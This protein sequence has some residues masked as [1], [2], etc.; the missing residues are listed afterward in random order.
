MK[1]LLAL[2]TLLASSSGAFAQITTTCSLYGNT[3]Y[4]T[5]YD[6]GA[7]VAEERREQ[8]A[9]GQQIGAGIG[10]GIFRAH[11]PGWR[12]KYCSAHPMQPYNYAN[13]RGDSI[14]GTCP[15]QD[16]LANEAATE[17]MAKHLQYGASEAN[18]LAM[19]SYIAQNHLARWEPK[20][21]DQAYKALQKNAR[22]HPANDPL[23]IR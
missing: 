18:G 21:Y 8:Y 11:F 15:T 7:Q 2:L 13:A 19:D 22:V 16:V 23:G 10:M 14:S 1:Y 6:Q 4:C 17:W 12:R 3:A 5:S 9:A 20:S